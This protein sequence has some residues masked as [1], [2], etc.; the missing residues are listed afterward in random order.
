MKRVHHR[1]R[2]REFFGSSS[3]EAGEPIH[4][5]DLHRLTPR[6]VT[7]GEPSL[8]HGLGSAGNHV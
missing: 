7:V 2:V 6:W 4:R 1:G 3:F 5:D 8:E